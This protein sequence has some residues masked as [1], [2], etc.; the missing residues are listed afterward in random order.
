MAK[1]SEEQVILES[2]KKI[3]KPQTTKPN[4]R[5][6]LNNLDRIPRAQQ[7][8]EK[9]SSRG[10]WGVLGKTA[11]TALD[12]TL[13]KPIQTIDTGRRAI[14]STV[15][16][17]ADI[18]DTDPDTRASFSDWMRQTKDVTYGGGTAFPVS[19]W[20]GRI[21]GF[22]IDVGLDP[23]TYAT[24]GGA[25]PAKA[26]IKGGV[27][28]GKSTRNVVGKFAIGRE[29]RQKLANLVKTRIEEMS[30]E[31]N[32]AV[33]AWGPKEINR[34]AGEVASK[35]K[36]ALYSYPFLMDD[37]GIKGPGVYYFGSRVKVPG[38]GGLGVLLEK[39]IVKTRLGFA[40]S[41]AG[42]ALARTFTPRGVGSIEQFGPNQIRD[43]RIA[44]AQ[45]KLSPD[46]VGKALEIL[47]ADDFKRIQVGRYLDE[48]GRTA[49]PLVDAAKKSS[50]PTHRLLDKVKDPAAT[51][52]ADGLWTNADDVARANGIKQ[53]L[54]NMIKSARERAVKVG[55]REPGEIVDGYFPRMETEAAMRHR[56][57]IGDDA[58]DQKVYGP[59]KS[60]TQSVFKE[61]EL[62]P[63]KIW[64]RT[65]LSGDE[66]VEELNAIAR[67][68]GEVNFD[69]FETDIANVMAKYVR[70]YSEQMATY[71]MVERLTER[72]IISWMQKALVIDPDFGK[73]ALIDAPRQQ[74]QNMTQSLRG[75][76]SATNGGNLRIKV[77]LES[78]LGDRQSTLA[79][80]RSG[81]FSPENLS[82]L[83][84]AL[85]DALKSSEAANNE[86]I[87]LFRELDD[88]IE[89]VDGLS[90]YALIKS[91]REE[92]QNQFEELRKSF[93][94]IEEMDSI[95]VEN[96]L[97]R[98]DAYSKRLQR[99]ERDVELLSDAHAYLPKVA[100]TDPLNGAS[101]YDALA[102][103]SKLKGLESSPTKPIAKWD[104]ETKRLVSQIDDNKAEGSFI[105]ALNDA[106]FPDADDFVIAPK[107]AK[108]AAKRK[109]LIDAYIKRNNLQN[110]I[111]YVQARIIANEEARGITGTT[112]LTDLNNSATV[113][114]GNKTQYG[115]WAEG[116]L[117]IE[118]GDVQSGIYIMQDLLHE[119][120]SL[121]QYLQWRSVLAPYGIEPGDDIV[122]EILIRNAKNMLNDAVRRGDTLRSDQLR[123]MVTITNAD[124]TT[125]EILNPAGV[126]GRS[127]GVIDSAQHPFGNSRWALQAA[128]ESDEQLE[129][130][131]NNA[132][133]RGSGKKSKTEILKERTLAEQIQEELKGA[134][135]ENVAAYN[136][137][138]SLV[139]RMVVARQKDIESARIQL[140]VIQTQKEIAEGPYVAMRK[141]FAER[142]PPEKILSTEDVNNIEDGIAKVFMTSSS[143]KEVFESWKASNGDYLSAVYGTKG[144]F[145]YDVV[146]TEADKR[147]FAQKLID[148][149]E[150]HI[151]HAYDKKIAGLTAE[152]EQIKD[153]IIRLVDDKIVFE[154]NEAVTPKV[155]FASER[156]IAESQEIL[157]RA[158]GVRGRAPERPISPEQR[159]PK[160]EYTKKEAS[161]LSEELMSGDGYPLAKM[162]Q[163]YGNIGHA[164][165]SLD[166]GSRNDA[167][168]MF[169]AQEWEQ[170]VNGEKISLGPT[171]KMESL[172]KTA[173]NRFKSLHREEWQAVNGQVSDE[174]AIQ[175]MVQ[176]II[177]EN[178]ESAA[179]GATA[180]A[181]R[182]NIAGNWEKTDGYNLLSKIN[183]L[184]A[185]WI[186][187]DQAEKIKNHKYLMDRAAQGV[188]NTQRLSQKSLVELDEWTPESGKELER[189]YRK[190]SA[191]IRKRG[192]IGEETTGPQAEK[193]ERIFTQL[194]SLTRDGQK[195]IDAVLSTPLERK[196]T[197]QI[198][199]EINVLKKLKNDN[200]ETPLITQRGFR[201]LI[202]ERE[203]ILQ[204]KAEPLSAK[205]KSEEVARRTSVKDSAKRAKQKEKEELALREMIDPDAKVWSGVENAEQI[206]VRQAMA[207]EDRL[208]QKV[209][210]PYEETESPVFSKDGSLRA[211]SFSEIEERNRIE[212]LSQPWAALENYRKTSLRNVP[213]SQARQ[214][215]Q[216]TNATLDGLRAEFEKLISPST[217]LVDATRRQAAGAARRVEQARAVY[218]QAEALSKISKE[219][220]EQI[221]KEVETITNLLAQFDSTV[222][223]TVRGTADRVRTMREVAQR[224]GR[225]YETLDEAS[226]RMN[227]ARDVVEL[228]GKK[229]ELDAVDA[230]ILEQVRA[231]AAFYDSVV[232]MRQA[233]YD[234]Q[235]L[236]TTRGLMDSGAVL[237]PG[238]KL[239]L[240]DGSIVNGLPMDAIVE[241]NERMVREGFAVLNEKYF[242]ELQASKEFANMWENATRISDPE[243]IR[244]LVYYVGPV[245]KAWKAFAVLS[246]GF[247]VR[248]AIANAVTFTMAG[249]NIDNLIRITPIYFSWA[250]AQKAGVPWEQWLRTQPPEIIPA[251][252]TAR[253]GALGSGGGIFSETFK[254]AVGGNKIYDNWL[255]RKNYALGQAAD[256]YMRFALAFDT[257]IKGGD[258]GLA[259]ARVKRFYFDYEDLST[260]DKALRQII[261]F[262]LWTSRNLSMHMQNMWLNPRPYLIYESLK[263]NFRDRETVDP[264][265]VRELSGFKLPFG[266][267]LYAM[268]DLGFNRIRN[269]AG[270]FYDPNTFIN[271][272]NPLIK[273]GAEQAMGKTAFSGKKLDDTQER[274]LA[275]LRA[276]APPAGQAE[277]L[278][279]TDG[280]SQLN[281]WLGYLGSPVR[282]YN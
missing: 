128:K 272:S 64:F 104:A 221:Q 14:I 263:R 73:N 48:I 59:D 178:P 36:Q 267:G 266:E 177:A 100:T 131:L 257:G 95:G 115:R 60:R 119:Q 47:D 242:P 125:S 192:F 237:L 16:E 102:R 22:V 161:E 146:W 55:A 188:E 215:T 18:L 150:E 149:A 69:I 195:R 120:V 227:A 99:F 223:P 49:Q 199:D 175:R 274:I 207:E 23:L 143:G 77:A 249:G 216:I 112:F 107:N 88:I 213:I 34:I 123:S 135:L 147:Q 214:E 270:I 33:A 19:G 176:D 217:S 35:G 63:G 138:H 13:L 259:Q 271:R 261:P 169:S 240:T 163:R 2:L 211:E 244:K 39:G 156:G 145:R 167:T 228:I 90:N 82:Q 253:E 71:D 142:Y 111:R 179:D 239:R 76:V 15:R 38:S 105:S 225:L 27:L 280:L 252:Q 202:R 116:K 183:E 194:L 235:M 54:A 273:I 224:R 173:K 56:L 3:G 196:S 238:G 45:G 205:Q 28:A 243:W 41:A 155:F 121:T 87:S 197:Q 159:T 172:V 6:I 152:A 184:R 282:K 52:G 25:V 254:E 226:Q 208:G 201:G 220:V 80:L 96:L 222:A 124:G 108:E 248:N 158:E 78:L 174:T 110:L 12:L 209:T 140:S 189:L 65:V 106:V 62:G 234:R 4:A 230:V 276:G 144:P 137:Y 84:L 139:R 92:L 20:K 68:S 236:Q 162:Q 89:D 180:V 101:L 66:T 126:Y 153:E 57:K 114:G 241:S 182:Q 247:H 94:N 103:I 165:S 122:D 231:Q 245:T 281:A 127:I 268:P 186:A 97:N 98:F 9:P 185:A 51:L 258:V 212:N 170:I 260:G 86:Y 204:E 31:G 164:L 113:R 218:D 157:V 117:L 166:H 187:A 251:L 198:I 24:L 85:D 154:T 136:K 75:W 190:A 118:Q 256:N 72:G 29:G 91:R 200:V 160:R 44:L 206:T 81:D 203:R 278:F 79:A 134:S 148:S 168:K 26:L 141:K 277:R 109:S 30:L 83:K 232:N 279:A 246:P 264:P 5:E 151:Q 133:F 275:A 181:R 32:R 255:T 74:L 37:I 193:N 17:V 262:W 10:P 269:D 130:F 67:R 70:A 229:G 21:M 219:S 1:K 50:V 265:F 233:Q 191:A 43:F 171:R 53:L 93:V 61:R 11:L 129:E 42:A 250:K 8:V 58:F 40:T 210:N 7:S 46:D 132:V